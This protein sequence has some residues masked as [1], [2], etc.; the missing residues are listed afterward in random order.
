[1]QKWTSPWHAR[2]EIASSYAASSS[3]LEV[4]RSVTRA[5]ILVVTSLVILGTNR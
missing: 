1:M 2:S 4:L 5:R 3:Y